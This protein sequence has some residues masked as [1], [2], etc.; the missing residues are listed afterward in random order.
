M[1]STDG[2]LHKRLSHLTQ[3]SFYT[4]SGS[5]LHTG[6][7]LDGDGGHENVWQEDLTLEDEQVEGRCLKSLSD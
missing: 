2:T 3:W 1:V 4:V 7:S 5:K 6:S